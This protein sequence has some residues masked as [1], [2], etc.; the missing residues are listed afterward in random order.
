M[1]KGASFLKCITK[2]I[3]NYQFDRSISFL[4]YANTLYLILTKYINHF[5][6]I[7]ILLLS[8][9]ECIL[10]TFY[11]PQG[12]LFIPEKPDFT[13]HS[14]IITSKIHMRYKSNILILVRTVDYYLRIPTYAIFCFQGFYTNTE[15]SNATENA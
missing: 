9:D 11:D 15:F 8:V 5:S 10:N 1:L 13:Q 2:K 3:T 14:P 4:A 7:E 12:K 6:Y